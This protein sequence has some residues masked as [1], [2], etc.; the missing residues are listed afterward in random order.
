MSDLDDFR[1]Q[2]DDDDDELIPVPLGIEIESPRKR[3]KSRRGFLGLTAGER[4]ILS[5]LLFLVV[6]IL[7]FGLLILTERVVL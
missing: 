5:V 3:K 1:K 2:L 6:A 7:G 4:A